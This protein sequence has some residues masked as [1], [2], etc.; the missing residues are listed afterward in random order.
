MSLDKRKGTLLLSSVTDPYLRPER[1]Y[2]LTRSIIQV[3]AVSP[4]LA[5]S[6]SG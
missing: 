6:V 4:I 1:K 5:R 2:L 3:A